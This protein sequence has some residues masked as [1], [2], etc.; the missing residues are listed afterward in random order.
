ME[1]HDYDA[2][3]LPSVELA[4]LC[5]PPMCGKTLYLRETF[6]ATH[7]RVCIAEEAGSL[8]AVVKLVMG[9]LASGRNVVLDGEN[10]LPA[11]REAF[12]LAARKSVP[13][14][15]LRAVNF[16]PVG[17][18]HQ[19]LWAREHAVV[20]RGQVSGLASADDIQRWFLGP[21]L[22]ARRQEGFVQVSS[23]RSQL[24]TNIKL[25]ARALL[26]DASA[27]WEFARTDGDSY[28]VR[29]ARPALPQLLHEWQRECGDAPVVVLLAE[30]LVFPSALALYA[31]EPITY[32]GLVDLYRQQLL[33]AIASIVDPLR[34]VC[35]VAQEYA[36]TEGEWTLVAQA[37]RIH[38]L[39]LA[40]CICI[41]GR[42][43]VFE[44][45]CAQYGI[46][47]LGVDRLCERSGWNG[48]A[49]VRRYAAPA[50]PPND[51]TAFLR[52]AWYSDLP[53]VASVPPQAS[54]AGRYWTQFESDP[55]VGMMVPVSELQQHARPTAARTHRVL[56]AWLHAVADDDGDAEEAVP[57][58]KRVKNEPAHE[59][60]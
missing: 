17:G 2:P 57:A 21:R 58:V 27:A 55:S 7:T 11:T 44:P 3:V 13:H 6:A 18:L 41:L 53:D 32:T 40:E 46:R 28:A 24:Y 14:A 38:G 23:V 12:T 47:T 20:E 35:V 45:L 36:S 15:R 60:E 29:L 54:F 51:A 30:S 31:E 42:A 16:Y 8:H 10:A 25:T 19:C 5:G 59:D 37:Q 52:D 50:P 4:V 43:S 34:R 22:M 49:R 33:R 1:W 26:V 39:A 56:P 9:L 48:A